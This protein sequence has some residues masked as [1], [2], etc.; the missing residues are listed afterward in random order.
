MEY[1]NLESFSLK[2]TDELSGGEV[3]KVLIARALAQQPEV[4]LLD[5]PTSALDLKNQ[6]DVMDMVQKYCK[7]NGIMTIVS[8]HD[9]NLSLR[10]A[11]NF[12][13]LKDKR[14]YQYGNKDI[15]TSQTLSDIYS[16]EVK[17]YHLDGNTFVVPIKQIDSPKSNQSAGEEN[18]K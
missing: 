10:Y 8:I 16:V 12:I 3:Q 6:L 17:V 2:Y 1:L 5:E 7:D 9:I 18:E 11:T 15:L 14:I 4:L 13:L